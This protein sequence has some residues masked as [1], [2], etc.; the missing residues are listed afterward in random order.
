MGR[1]AEVDGVAGALL[2]VHWQV[3]LYASVSCEEVY[4]ERWLG[5]PRMG[6]LVE[7]V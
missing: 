3:S 4:Y 5:V 7:M 6:I 1:L 2:S